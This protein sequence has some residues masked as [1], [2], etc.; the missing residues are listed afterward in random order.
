MLTSHPL[1]A[2]PSQSL[3]LPEQAKLQAPEEHVVVALL[4]EGQIFP[5]APQFDVLVLTLTSQP[6][7]A[8]P[9]QFAKP[10]LQDPRPHEPAEH[11]A[12]ALVGLGQ[13]FP[14]V[15]QLA[16]LVLR[17]VSQPFPAR[18]SQLPKPLLHAPS[19]QAPAAQAGAALARPA[20][21]LPHVPQLAASV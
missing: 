17:F 16:V 7:P 1:A 15:P 21:A 20:Q 13:A 9:S 11:A 14:H 19:A 5:Q 6:L 12:D 4:R 3:K 2:L 10:A 18:P 8:T